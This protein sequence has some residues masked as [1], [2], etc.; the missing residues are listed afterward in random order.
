MKYRVTAR[1]ILEED[2]RILFVEYHDEHKKLYYSLPG[3]KQDIGENLQQTVKS[4]FREEVG[5]EIETGDIVLVREF[6]NDDPDIDIWEGGI[7]QIEIIFEC[8]RK[9]GVK[10]DSSQ[11]EPDNY[12]VGFKWIPVDELNKYKIYPCEELKEII[13]NRRV[14]YLFTEERKK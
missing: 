9:K 2:G 10:V 11:L 1:G 8:K 5:I 13:H 7:H 14:K 4:E 6:I 3:G 12:M